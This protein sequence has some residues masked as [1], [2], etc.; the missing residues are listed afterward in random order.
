M[1]SST[2]KALGEN[3]DIELINEQRFAHPAVGVVP[4][5]FTILDVAVESSVR[6]RRSRPNW[7][8]KDDFHRKSSGQRAVNSHPGFFD[9]SETYSK[10]MLTVETGSGV[11][12]VWRSRGE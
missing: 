4:T 12:I 5:P 10:L 1:R 7:K 8:N 9:D 11:E 3:A 2:R 6:A